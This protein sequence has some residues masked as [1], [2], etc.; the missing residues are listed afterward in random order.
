M[1]R[2]EYYEGPEALKRLKKGMTALFKIP[3]EAV[4]ARPKPKRKQI[5]PGK[6]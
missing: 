4:K 3:K 6:S 1:K 2:Y 5:T